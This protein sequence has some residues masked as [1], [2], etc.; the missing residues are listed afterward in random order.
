MNDIGRIGKMF[1]RHL[2]Q[3]GKEGEVA[4]R[5]RSPRRCKNNTCKQAASVQWEGFCYRHWMASRQAL[6]KK[7]KNLVTSVVSGGLPGLGK[8]QLAR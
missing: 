2:K 5:Q 1:R 4:A 6:K 8:R 3:V 7:P